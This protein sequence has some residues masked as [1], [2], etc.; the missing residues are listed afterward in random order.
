MDVIDNTRWN[1]LRNLRHEDARGWSENGLSVKED[2]EF[3]SK[4]MRCTMFGYPNADSFWM[5]GGDF[6]NDIY[7]F[8]VREQY[9]D[10]LIPD[11]DPPPPISHGFSGTFDRRKGVLY[12]FGGFDGSSYLGDVLYVLRLRL[13]RPSWT[14]VKLSGDISTMNG[15]GLHAASLLDGS[16]YIFG[17]RNKTGYLWH[18]IKIDVE[19]GRVTELEGSLDFCRSRHAAVS[20]DNHIYIVG[21]EYKRKY[22]FDLMRMDAAGKVSRLYSGVRFARGDHSLVAFGKQLYVFGGFNVDCVND[23]VVCDTETGYVEV[24]Y[25][26]THNELTPTGRCSHG[27]TVAS[28]KMYIFGG[29]SAGGLRN[30]LYSYQLCTAHSIEDEELRSLSSLVSELEKMVDN[31]LMSDVKLVC[32]D[33]ST[34][35]AHAFVLA[36]R[37]DYFKSVLSVGIGKDGVTKLQVGG[38]SREALLEFIQYI[39]TGRLPHLEDVC[40]EMIPIADRHGI[41]YLKE[42]C[43][44]VAVLSI[45]KESVGKRLEQ[46]QLLKLEFLRES[47]LDYII[48]NFENMSVE[49]ASRLPADALRE[50]L[51]E[52][53]KRP[54]ADR[55][56]HTMNLKKS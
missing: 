46:A 6:L 32:D 35:S 4:R 41:T 34:I 28:G 21:G 15:R 48:E 29:Y 14:H 26:V 42:H 27:A 56:L 53:S 36:A 13:G 11:G 2:A 51:C 3:P 20:I 45:S 10:S 37:S 30:D 31:E 38:I 16:L 5:Y 8:H 47:C 12:V 25:P 49:V 52:V 24:Q 23:V 50:A 17:G 18:P 1:R 9:W 7:C 22:L 19:T 55:I 44:E 43:K 33:D 54:D 39:Y 40:I